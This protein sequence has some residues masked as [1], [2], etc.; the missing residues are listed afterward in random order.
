MTHGSEFINSLA[1]LPPSAEYPDG[2]VISGARDG[3][4]DVRLPSSDPSH[5]ALRLLIGHSN[6]VCTLD[7]SPSGKYIV[8]GGW[9]GQARVWSVD[10]WETE[11]ELEGHGTGGSNDHKGFWGVLAY[12]ENTVFTGCADHVI[13][14][15]D[16]RQQKG[17][18]LQP[19]LTIQTPDIVRALCRLPAGHPSGANIA[20]AGNDGVVRLWKLSGQQVAELHGHESFVYSLDCLPSGELVSSGE[21][22]TVRIWNGQECVQ[23][24]THP[25]ISVWSVAVCRE[26]GDIVSGASDKMARVFTRSQDRIAS[27]EIVREFQESVKSSAIPQQQMGTV[28]KEKLPGPEYLKSRS[29]TKE[30]Q[31]TMV[32]EDD[33]SVSAHQWSMSE[34]ASLCRQRNEVG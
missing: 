33:G 23:T 20:S 9:D 7:V 6:N 15:F 17:G 2:L 5:D 8:S 24:I 4:I 16:L 18:V 1:Y 30:G 14:G 31:I 28:N 13:R 12:D 22:R 26:S 3:L 25:A 10:K 21:D 19:S 27:A 29:G 34:F 11:I 32:K